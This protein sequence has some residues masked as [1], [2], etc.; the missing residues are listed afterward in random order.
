MLRFARQMCHQ[1]CFI[2]A[3]VLCGLLIQL[4]FQQLQQE[5]LLHD[6]TV[7]NGQ[8]VL[9]VTLYIYGQQRLPSKIPQL[10]SGCPLEGWD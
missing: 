7:R 3:A 8:E 4:P 6:A 9:P 2:P 1:D 10:N 5:F